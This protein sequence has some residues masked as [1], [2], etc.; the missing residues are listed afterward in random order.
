M[1]M[2]SGSSTV[3]KIK[4]HWVEFRKLWKRLEE[5]ACFAIPHG[6]ALF[7]EW[8]RGCRY[9]RNSN[10]ARFLAKY[11]FEFVDFDGCMYGFV[12]LH[13]K[14]A[15]LPIKKPWR[16]AYLDSS[17]GDFLSIKCDRSRNH[18]SCSGQNASGTGCY[19]PITYC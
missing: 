12:A 7:I 14:G 19:T 9:W 10:V 17:L 18:S 13:G 4:G 6:V 8:P 2:H 11:G 3:A 16:V 1:N 5:I 15:G